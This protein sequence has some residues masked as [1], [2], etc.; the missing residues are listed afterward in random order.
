VH[1]LCNLRSSLLHEVYILTKSEGRVFATLVHLPAVKYVDL[2]TLTPDL[3]KFSIYD[4]LWLILKIV[5]P[6]GHQL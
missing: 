2:A 5:R 6:S 4:T 3:S 1:G